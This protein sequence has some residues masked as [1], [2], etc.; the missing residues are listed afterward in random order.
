[1]SLCD[2]NATNQAIAMDR[3]Q[4]YFRKLDNFFSVKQQDAI[5]TDPKKL[6]SSCL[7]FSHG[8][9]DF[10]SSYISFSIF[11]NLTFFGTTEKTNEK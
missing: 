5:R 10:Q 4:S 9:K 1:M 11:I 6:F 8:G 7:Q 3:F 2:H